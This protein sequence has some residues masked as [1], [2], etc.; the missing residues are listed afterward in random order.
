MQ[1]RVM[2]GFIIALM[3]IISG[4][5]GGSSGSTSSLDTSHNAPEISTEST[6]TTTVASDGKIYVDENKKEAYQI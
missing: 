1:K 6:D 5:G 3:L 2:I 4:C